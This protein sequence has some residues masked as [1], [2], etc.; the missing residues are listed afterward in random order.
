MM[1]ARFSTEFQGA[2]WADGSSGPA[3][4]AAFVG[5]NKHPAAGEWQTTSTISGYEPERLF[6]WAVG[7]TGGT[8]RIR[9]RP[10]VAL[11]QGGLDDPARC[12]VHRASRQSPLHLDRN[13]CQ[14]FSSADRYDS[15]G[16]S[17]R[18][19]APIPS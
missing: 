17:A 5:R 3:L 11:G 15:P 18:V 10:A 12:P 19:P 9:D 1:P 16:P 4:G 13:F 14:D 7:G 8:D 2:D 6:E